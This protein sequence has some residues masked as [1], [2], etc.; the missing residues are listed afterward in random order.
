MLMAVDMARC[1]GAAVP[2][3]LSPELDDAL[4]VQQLADQLGK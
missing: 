4:A 3:G 1:F 2:P